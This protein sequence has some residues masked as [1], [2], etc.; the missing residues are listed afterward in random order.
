MPENHK[1]EPNPEKDFYSRLL[2]RGTGSAWLVVLIC[3]LIG[4][5][6]AY[7]LAGLLK[8][9]YEGT[10][11]VSMNMELVPDT[12]I[13]EIMVDAEINHIGELAW[14]PDVVAGLSRM[15]PSINEEILRRS[16]QVERQLMNTLLRYRSASAEE[17]AS[18]ASAW[19]EALYSRLLEAYPYALKVS[20][21]KA[22]LAAVQNCQN[23]EE[24]AEL[25]F[26]E[27][28]T[29]ERARDITDDA[30]TQ[31][32]ANAAQSLG[33]TQDLNPGTVIPAVNPAPQ[34]V[35]RRGDLTLAGA[36]VGL[37]LGVFLAEVMPLKRRHAAG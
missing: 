18:V 20:E 12:N 19:A 21:A 36:V 33:L 14:H 22:S 37:A 34:V 28:L 24:K 3:A 4:A 9:V 1:P 31:I 6:S 15:Q 26:C 10:A 16:G 27:D 11:V 17:A 29:D 35:N 2:N 32:E 7:F 25:P 8:P 30:H 13:T 23:D 5:L